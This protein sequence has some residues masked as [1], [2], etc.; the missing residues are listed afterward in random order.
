[1][2]T[3]EKTNIRLIK[4]L[5]HIK[6]SILNKLSDLIININTYMYCIFE[7]SYKHEILS[8]N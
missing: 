2:Q 1:M 7:S 4:Q 3:E 6:L 5:K 8:I